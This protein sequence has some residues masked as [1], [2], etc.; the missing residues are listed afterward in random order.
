[1]H[2]RPT[3]RI[4][5]VVFWGVTWALP[6][7]QAWMDDDAKLTERVVDLSVRENIPCAHTT[8]ISFEADPAKVSSSLALHD[9]LTPSRCR[10]PAPEAHAYGAAYNSPL[11]S[12]PI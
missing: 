9:T 8:V 10:H 6:S 11:L 5:H 2:P 7:L 3:W 12:R 4:A 1:M